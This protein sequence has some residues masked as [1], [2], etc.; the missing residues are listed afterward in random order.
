MFNGRYGTRESFFAA[1]KSS[2]VRG[3]GEEKEEEGDDDDD[4]DDDGGVEAKGRKDV[5]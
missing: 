2:R 5:D 4:D 1:R 3:E